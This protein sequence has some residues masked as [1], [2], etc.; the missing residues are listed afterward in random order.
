VGLVSLGGLIGSLIGLMLIDR[1]GRRTILICSDIA[2]IP[3]SLLCALSTGYWQLMLGRAVM[4][5]G[6][7][8][9]L[10]ALPVYISEVATIRRRGIYSSLVRISIA[11]GVVFA[12][13]LGL[14]LSRAP[15]WR[16]MQGVPM[17][18]TVIQALLLSVFCVETPMYLASR[19]QIEHATLT[20][21]RLRKG[22]DAGVEMDMIS[23]I[24]GKVYD[25]F[26]DTS[27]QN[28]GS[29]EEPN[30]SLSVW[31]LLRSHMAGTAITVTV[32][33]AVQQLCGIN[34]IIMYGAGFL[35]TTFDNGTSH[36]LSFSVG[37]TTLIATLISV[38][39]VERLGR[40]TLLLASLV[41]LTLTS[42][43]NFV[44]KA[45]DQY[46]PAAVATFLF[47]ASFAIGLSPTPWLFV[48]ELFPPRAVGA[49]SVLCNSAFW[50]AQFLAAQTFPFIQDN[51]GKY[52]FAIF[53]GVNLISA[54][55][56][57]IRLVETKG[58]PLQEIQNQLYGSTSSGQGLELSDY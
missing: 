6:A 56:F 46:V 25:I 44:L 41:G 20:L 55:F 27:P 17:V 18:L 15:G 24:F 2:F 32:L 8:I 9:G 43:A 1:C 31:Q 23:K 21:Y 4:G 38:F 51:V 3:G 19:G 29:A 34:I 58:K 37:C 54:V 57:A 48:S 39:L 35:D 7:G 47:V 33:H 26:G 49:V 40:K 12:L 16:Y 52:A 36:F 50:L 42:T 11:A 5:I 14:A 13:G 53:C 30:E 10:V 45:T 28:I 22:Y